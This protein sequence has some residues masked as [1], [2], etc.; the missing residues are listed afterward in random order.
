MMVHHSLAF[1]LRVLQGP[2]SRQV[3][4]IWASITGVISPSCSTTC[5]L[6]GCHQ[7]SDSPHLHLL[8]NGKQAC[9]VHMLVTATARC[10]NPNP[11]TLPASLPRLTSAD[12]IVNTLGTLCSC[13]L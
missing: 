10:L 13:M 1:S 3:Q 9:I 7:V 2:M 6:F 8:R 5:E 4:L 12:K 11:R